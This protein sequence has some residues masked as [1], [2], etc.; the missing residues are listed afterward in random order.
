VAK[1]VA[2][3]QLDP[4]PAAGATVIARETR[5][6][7]RLTGGRAVR[8]EGALHGSVELQAALEIVAGA[9]VEAE[10]HAS[11]VRIA[12]SVTGNVVATE[13]VELLASG[14]VKGDITTPALHVVEGARLE[15]RVQMRVDG[16]GAE[17]PA[18]GDRETARNR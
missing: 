18:A 17:E 3:S 14:L 2:G 16:A 15:G 9:T 7:G 1:D 4:R 6:E 10:V 5:G 8:V 11:V 13:L 12:G